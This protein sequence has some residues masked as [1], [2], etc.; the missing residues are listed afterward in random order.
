MP[1]P[2]D[3]PPCP[4]RPRAARFRGRVPAVLASL[5]AL[6]AAV[7]GGGP[8]AAGVAGATGQSAGSALPVS[9]TILNVSP[10][11][12]TAKHPVVVSGIVT[13][14]SGSALAGLKVQLR[15]SHSALTSRDALQIY[16]DGTTVADSQIGRAS[17][18]ERV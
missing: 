7:A 14:T 10:D 11:Y 2:P 8:A 17:C 15:S 1:R 12:L 5:C 13:N 3:H 18:R 4:G 6:A 16:A 9:L